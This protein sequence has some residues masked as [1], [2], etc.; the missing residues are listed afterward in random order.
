MVARERQTGSPLLLLNGSIHTMDEQRPTAQAILIE[1]GRVSRVGTN[2]EF[3]SVGD[4][5]KLDLEGMTVFPGFV[6]S[7]V[8][9]LSYGLSLDEVDL[10]EARSIGDVLEMLREER[11][12][13]AV[14]R[15]S[16]LD[17]DSLKERR[18]PNRL[19]LDSVFGRVPAFVKRRDEHSSVINTAALELL[20][21]SPDTPGIDID[22]STGE[23][24]GVLKMQANQYA[25]EKFHGMMEPDEMKEAYARAARTA[26]EHGVTTIHSL[27]GSDEN[28]ERRDCET[29][30]D[31]IDE[32]PA[33]IIPYYQTRDVGKVLG[34]G[35]DRIGGC[36]LIDGSIGSRTAAF[37]SE[38]ADDPG[39]KGCLY[40]GE[41]ELL[42][43]FES[44]EE[45][46]LQ[47]AVHAIGDRAVERALSSYERLLARH[48]TRDH[49][50]RIEHAEYVTDHQ[51]E[52]I[53]D[54]GIC[55]GMQPAFEGFWGGD[56]QMYDVRLGRERAGRL[57]SL[58]KAVSYGICVAGGSDAP[59]T[60]PDPVYGIHCAVNHPTEES[61]VTLAEAIRMFTS[62]GAEIAHR[63]SE[64]GVLKAGY[65]GDLVGVSPDPFSAKKEDLKETEVVLVIQNGEVVF[66]RERADRRG[67]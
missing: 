35:L 10:T 59:I 53:A 23:P 11:P 24:S 55:L 62:K 38:Y 21:L 39:N 45:S 60:P 4:A 27:V 57:N 54:S 20:S 50:H 64:L 31:M 44:A 15:A 33:R 25:L 48:G 19:E 51:F 18:Y 6:D 8:H 32:L 37:G 26:V 17:P 12:R 56:G 9:L 5:E 40:I 58:A 16:Q 42:S 13:G 63:E 14:V 52:R 1:S 30:L 47:I 61:R 65:H 2:E 3:L 29:L 49:R 41:D 34:L 46:G 67:N 28:P 66:R 43:F 36:I 7:H 22:P